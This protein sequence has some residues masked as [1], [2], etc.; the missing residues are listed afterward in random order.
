MMTIEQC[1]QALGGSFAEV[2][3]RLPSVRLVEKFIG[4]F[5][6]DGSF[7]ELCRQ[8]ASGSRQEAFR[9]AH[10]LKGVC[11]NLGFGRL[12][13][14]SG[15]LTEVLRAVQGMAPSFTWPEAATLSISSVTKP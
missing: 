8:V 9:A 4:K 6:D 15:R 11:A 1:Y 13:S 14:S 7:D 10:T 2:S 12:L 5:L 3:M